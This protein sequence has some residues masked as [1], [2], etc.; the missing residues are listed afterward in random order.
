V[1]FPTLVYQHFSIWLL[2]FLLFIRKFKLK[3]F[4]WKFHSFCFQNNSLYYLV[5]V[6][7]MIKVRWFQNTASRTEFLSLTVHNVINFPLATAHILFFNLRCIRTGG[8]NL[9]GI[10]ELQ[11]TH[12]EWNYPLIQFTI[13]TLRFQLGILH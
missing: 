9:A 13:C 7:L 11:V 12:F 1:G 10:S 5:E 8:E 2:V 4:C 6:Y 3:C